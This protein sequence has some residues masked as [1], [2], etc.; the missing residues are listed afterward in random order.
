MDTFAD[1]LNTDV[2]QLYTQVKTVEYQPA[3]IANG[4]TDLVNEIQ[5]SKITGEEERYSH[6]DLLDFDGNLAGANEAVNVLMPTLKQKDPALATEVTQ[7][8]EATAAALKKY[9]ATP[10]YE[11]SGYVDYQKVTAAQRRT[12]SQTVDAYAE[13]VSKI[14]GKIA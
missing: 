4:A 14:A 6:I 13:S 2:G 8:Y 10:G 11:D 3:E 7:R 12:L 1:Q 5:S 9:A